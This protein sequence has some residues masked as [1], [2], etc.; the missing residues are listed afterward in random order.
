M[1]QKSK[2]L[3]I[4]SLA[5]L[6]TVQQPPCLSLYQPTHRSRSENQQDP[7]RF[8]NLAKELEVSLRPKYPA[9][10]TRLVLEPFA[11]LAHDDSFWNH[12]REGLAVLGGPILFRVFRL[13]RPVAELASARLNAMNVRF[14]SRLPWGLAFSFARAIQQPALEIWHGDDANKKAA[15]QALFHR[16][17][18]NQAARRGEY[19]A[20]W[21]GHSNDKHDNSPTDGIGPEV[22][23]H[24]SIPVDRCS[25]T[26]R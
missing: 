14:K 3:S 24:H 11:A 1:A 16:V 26:G 17:K 4:E 6:A 13:Q 10:E 25:A 2:L 5:E 15:Q 21:K 18:C 20:Q 23:Q 22:N 12:T 9:V 7:I 19:T 8:R